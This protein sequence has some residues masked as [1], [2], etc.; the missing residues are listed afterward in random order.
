MSIRPTQDK[1]FIDAKAKDEFEFICTLINY[2]GVGAPTTR[3]N[4]FEWF[5]AISFYEGFFKS[6]NLTHHE[7]ARLALMIYCTFFESSDLYTMLGNLA[8][9]VL[10]HRATPYLYWKHEKAN[11][12]FGTAEKISMVEEVLIDSGFEDIQ[13]FFQANH[14]EQ[15]RHAFF[16]STYAFDDDDYVM[17]DVKTLYIDNFGHP[18]LSISSFIFPRVEA[19][20]DFFHS[21]KEILDTHIKSYITD[22]MVQGRMP[23]LIP[24]KI[25]G[26]DQGLIG[27]HDSRGG[28]IELKSDLWMA[29]NIRFHMQ[30]DVDRHVGD[31]LQRLFS[32]TKIST[33]DGAL[34]DFT[35]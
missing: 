26:S 3:S 12:W 8:R 22:K 21:F 4:Q 34:Q 7:K 19:V 14:F 29:T 6:P 23:D 11:R 30:N 17:H 15:I 20:L 33:N 28:S 35:R 13:K 16:H 18:T 25:L 10:G 31:E 9:V 5:S 1:L 27:F 24:I 2:K 32:K